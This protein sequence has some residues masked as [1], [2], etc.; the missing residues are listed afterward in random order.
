MVP[1]CILYN[2]CMYVSYFDLDELFVTLHVSDLLSAKIKKLIYSQRIKIT[3]DC[4]YIR[5]RYSLEGRLHREDGPA[6]IQSTGDL[7]WYQNNK[8]HREDGPAAIWM[9]GTK[10]Y[11]INDQLHRVAGPAIIQSNGSK[12]YYLNGKLHRLDGPAMENTDGHKE[13]FIHGKK[14]KRRDYLRSKYR[15]WLLTP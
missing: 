9:D 11:Y 2:I 7:F 10:R 12:V 8:F 1:D 5:I 6:L 15:K 14:Y 13:Y 4:G 3:D